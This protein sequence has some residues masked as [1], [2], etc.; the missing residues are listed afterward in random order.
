MR[1]SSE[2]P[3][4]SKAG[5]LVGNGCVGAYHSPGTSPFGDRAL[6]DRPDGLTGDA[7]EDIEPALLRRLRDGLDRASVDGDVGEDRR[8]RDVEVPDAVMH[9]LIVPFALAGHADRRA[10][11]LSPNRPLPGRWPP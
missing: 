9:E 1:S 8:A 6:L 7:V 11:R 4:R 10:S 3:W 5:G 2:T